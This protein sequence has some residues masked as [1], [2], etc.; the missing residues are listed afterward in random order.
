MMNSCWASVEDRG[1][2]WAHKQC[3]VRC[4]FMYNFNSFFLWKIP[5]CSYF[6]ARNFLPTPFHS[7]P[8][9]YSFTPEWKKAR[10]S[11]LSND[12]TSI[13]QCPNVGRELLLQAGIEPT[14]Q[15]SAL[16]LKALNCFIKTIE[17]KGFYSIWKQTIINVLVSSFWFTWIPVLWVYGH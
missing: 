8:T 14:R 15:A 3:S 4:A 6:G 2:K 11:Y 16:T 9:R 17:T 10:E 5:K 7:W 1:S 12:T 13:K